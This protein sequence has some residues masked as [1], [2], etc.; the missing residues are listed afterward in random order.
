[1]RINHV[2]ILVKDAKIAKR[3]YNKVLGFE[4]LEKEKRLWIKIGKQFIHITDNSGKPVKGTF[5][6]F[7]IE[8]KGLVKFISKLK[9]NG[10][11]IFDVDIKTIGDKELDSNR[12]YFLRDPDGNLLEFIEANNSFFN[13]I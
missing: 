5:Y 12:N 1:M 9:N 13:P 11:K 6:H 8:I 7:S 2:T 4:V 10:I 3:F